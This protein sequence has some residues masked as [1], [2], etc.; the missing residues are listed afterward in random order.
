MAAESTKFG[1]VLIGDVG[2]LRHGCFYRLFNATKSSDDPINALCGVPADYSPLCYNETA[3]LH[4][5][6]Y[7]LPPG[8]VYSTSITRTDIKAGVSASVLF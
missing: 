5:I 3:L 8:P 6:D 7:Y 1:E 4:T 2:F